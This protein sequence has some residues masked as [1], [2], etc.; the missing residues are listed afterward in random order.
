MSDANPTPP[1][2]NEVV[3]ETNNSNSKVFI[4]I[5]I[6]L[7]LLVGLAYSF[8]G[9][10]KDAPL[11]AMTI[12]VA[13]HQS[14][15]LY[16]EMKHELA[17][18]KQ[19]NEELY[20]QIA[21]KESELENQYSRI[22]RLIIQ[23]KRDKSAKKEIETKLKDLTLEL[24][25]LKEYVEAQTLDLEELRVENRRLKKEKEALDAK[26][27]AELEERERLAKAGVDLQNAND[28]L[29]EK[30]QTASVL[31]TTNGKITALRLKNNG[32]RKSVIFA[33]RAEFLEICF[34]IVKNDVCETGPN[35]FFLRILDPSGAV[36]T[37][38]NRGSGALTLFDDSEEIHYTTSKIFEY[39]TQLTQLCMDWHAYPTTP[40]RAGTYRIEL[41]NKGRLV[42]QYSFTTK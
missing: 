37:D 19:D 16:K 26:Y 20:A 11:E 9:G 28:E 24:E 3:A 38:P 21:Q 25:N 7:V 2:S 6:V 34:N 22:K 23:A 1:E 33:K 13:S 29:N 27:A 31:Q 10:S 14:D 30:L 35:R 36:V 4:I 17:I 40:F 15:S 18:Y 5:G 39:S 41:Y 8:L 32:E 42:G 12:E